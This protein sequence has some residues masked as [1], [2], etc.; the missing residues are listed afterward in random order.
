MIPKNQL[1]VKYRRRPSQY[2]LL[3]F[4]VFIADNEIYDVPN[5]PEIKEHIQ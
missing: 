1:A 3:L 4:I 5:S 2:I